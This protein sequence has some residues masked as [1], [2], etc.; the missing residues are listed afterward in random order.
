MVE[1]HG[2]KYIVSFQALTR[3]LQAVESWAGL[4][5]EASTAVGLSLT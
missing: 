4:G 2:Q 3:V 1:A 5:N